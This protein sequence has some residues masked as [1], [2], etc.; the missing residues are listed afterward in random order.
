MTMHGEYEEEVG[1]EKRI[2]TTQ[3]NEQNLVENT[4]EKELE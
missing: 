1:V 2:D 3:T 4:K